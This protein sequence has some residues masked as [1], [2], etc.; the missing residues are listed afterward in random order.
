MQIQ[1]K[2]NKGF[3]LIELLVVV[4]IVGI[5]AS[6]AIYGFN[7]F[8]I[9]AKINATKSQHYQITKFIESSYGQCKLDRKKNLIFKTC[10][11]SN[12]W[13]CNFGGIIISPGQKKISCGESASNIA[14]AFVYHF[15]NEG[16]S[17]PYNTDGPV[18]AGIGGFNPKQCCLMQSWDPRPGS[19]HIWGVNNSNKIYIK[20]N[21]GDK[22]GKD[23][24]INDFVLWPGTG[25]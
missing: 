9:A 10:S 21:V 5:L 25:F 17:N 15:N 24:F 16:F 23:F 6:I 20:T 8:T 18:M 12:D 4:A 3:T 7:K 1:D 13:Y 2:K 19:T 22:D 14:F 11:S